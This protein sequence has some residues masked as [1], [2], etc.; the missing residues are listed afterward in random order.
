MSESGKSEE[1]YRSSA[2]T[3]SSSGDAKK[4]KGGPKSNKLRKAFGMR[5]RTESQKSVG[6]AKEMEGVV[7][8]ALPA[9]GTADREG[10][11]E[12]I[13]KRNSQRINEFH[14]APSASPFPP[15]PQER[16]SAPSSSNGPLALPGESDSDVE[17]RFLPRL[18]SRLELIILIIGAVRG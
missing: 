6:S 17:V 18:F 8:M 3:A 9:P 4:E 14:S 10:E 12:M 11:W 15:V 1:Y 5:G 13:S 2:L 7:N 16:Y